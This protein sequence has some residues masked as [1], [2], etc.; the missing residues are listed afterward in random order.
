MRKLL[1]FIFMDS[2]IW[3]YIGLIGYITIRLTLVALGI[4][5]ISKL[6]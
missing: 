1:N 3:M 6:F 5:A 4:F 2:L